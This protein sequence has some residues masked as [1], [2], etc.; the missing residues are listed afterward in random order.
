MDRYYKYK[1]KETILLCLQV[2]RDE[3]NNVRR[4]SSIF[5][6]HCD[7][8][9]NGLQLVVALL[10]SKLYPHVSLW[11]VSFSYISSTTWECELILG[12]DINICALERNRT[13]SYIHSGWIYLELNVFWCK[14]AIILYTVKKRFII[15]C[16]RCLHSL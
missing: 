2:N 4:N 6:G 10:L 7:W 9:F 15:Q 12:K 13:F 3:K 5:V 8:I 14:I 16:I 11:W 1:A